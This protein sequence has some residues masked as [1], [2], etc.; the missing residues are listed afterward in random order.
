MP[1]SLTLVSSIWF[2]LADE[3][4]AIVMQEDLKSAS[5][6]SLPSI[7][8][9]CQHHKNMLRLNCQKMKITGKGQLPQLR[10]SEIIQQS[11]AP[12][13]GEQAQ[14]RSAEPSS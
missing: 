5:Q 4:L 14:P 12:Q 1:S 10:P 8:R 2:A 3:M 7:L 9:H 11:D 13:M 6:S